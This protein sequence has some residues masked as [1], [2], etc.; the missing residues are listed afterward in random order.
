M[1]AP[2]AGLVL[3]AGLAIIFSVVAGHITLAIALDTTMLLLALVWL[4][5]L[6]KIPWDLYF[7]ARY[8]R[9]DG[10]ESV[11][12]GIKVEQQHL[13]DL[14]TL[15][16][17]LLW[18]ALGAHAITALAV[19][20]IGAHSSG[21][22]HNAFAWLFLGSAA[23]RPAWEFHYYLRARLEELATQVRYPREDVQ[24]LRSQVA[25]IESNLKSWMDEAKRNTA[26][27][28]LKD[29]QTSIVLQQA[30]TK[31][32]ADSAE[33]EKRLIQL[34]H[35]FEESVARVSADQELLAGVRAFARMFR[36]QN[37]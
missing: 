6:V 5:C 13:I 17:R 9:L 14:K 16:R 15:E 19:W 27:L 25:S 20:A 22:V 4:F 18:A 36:E 24:Q 2:L 23:L 26:E 37:A 29:E 30:Q 12:R 34:S 21:Q 33:L 32:I 8:A 10:E 3:A 11:K 35:K 28:T 31:Q 1:I 7:A